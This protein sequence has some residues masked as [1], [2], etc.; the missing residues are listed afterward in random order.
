MNKL[1]TDHRGGIDFMIL[2]LLSLLI[3]TLMWVTGFNW[4]NQMLLKQQLKLAADHAARAAAQDIDTTQLL[5]GKLTWNAVAGTSDFYVYLQR[6][7]KLDSS[8]RSS[9]GYIR[10]GYKVD[11]PLL[12]FVSSPFYPYTLSRSVTLYGGTVNQTTRK[13]D[14][15]IYGPS[16]VAVLGAPYFNMGSARQDAIVISTVASIRKR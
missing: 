9:G 10:A 8:N 7:L 1:W 13:V 5:Q 6:N 16:I 2:S 3:T 12:E 14:V 11:V 4:M 15:T